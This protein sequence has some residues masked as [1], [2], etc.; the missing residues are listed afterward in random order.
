MEKGFAWLLTFL[1]VGLLS[2]E[3]QGFQHRGVSEAEQ[4]RWICRRGVNVFV[5]GPS[6]HAE[7]VLL[8]PVHSLVMD[9]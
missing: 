4:D 6:R 2:K 5:V 7:H 9:D 8:F 1:G 3:T